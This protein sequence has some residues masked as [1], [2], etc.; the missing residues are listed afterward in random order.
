MQARSSS[1]GRSRTARLRCICVGIQ[2]RVGDPMLTDE[3]RWRLMRLL[4][5]THDMSQRELA[6]SLGVSVGKLNY[7]VQALIRSGWVNVSRFKNR[8]K[9]AAYKYFLT[10]RGAQEKALLTVKFLQLKMRE[11]ERLGFE[12]ELM[13]QEAERG[14]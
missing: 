1:T 3:M 4:D 7:C 13:R 9:K 12:I 8:Q 11:Y 2:G 6:L 10:S 14:L 5:M